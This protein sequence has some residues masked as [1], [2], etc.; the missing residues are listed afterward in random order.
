VRNFQDQA[1]KVGMDLVFANGQKAFVMGKG[2]LNMHRPVLFAKSMNGVFPVSL[3]NPV[4]ELVGLVS[5]GESGHKPSFWARYI[6]LPQDVFGETQI[7]RGYR[8]TNGVVLF[9]TGNEYWIDPLDN[10]NNKYSPEP[11]LTNPDEFGGYVVQQI[12]TGVSQY[13]GPTGWTSAKVSDSFQTYFQYCSSAPDSI[14]VTLGIVTWSWGF[15]GQFS[16]EAWNLI[17]N[18][19]SIPSYQ[20]SD[21]FPVWTGEVPNQ[22]QQYE[23]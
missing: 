8:E 21:L 6:A 1:V 9:N 22:G 3:D 10:F 19:M 15:D 2:E 13:L 17:P 16:N 20:D 12:D 5:L 23:Y 4:F 7:V 18:N 14:K 11:P